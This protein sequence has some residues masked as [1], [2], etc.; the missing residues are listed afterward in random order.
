MGKAAR[1]EE[2]QEAARDGRRMRT[3]LIRRL[4]RHD[5]AG[6]A[7][8]DVEVGVQDKETRRKR[9]DARRPFLV[10]VL[11]SGH[12]QQAVRAQEV[13]ATNGER[14]HRPGERR[15]AGEADH[16][17][18]GHEDASAVGRLEVEP[19]RNGGPHAVSV[20]KAFRDGALHRLRLAA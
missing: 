1:G 5:G 3:R 18:A 11:E 2:E 16:R 15:T 14:G 6:A 8:V 20:F 17:L 19:P 4:A 7:A 10:L 13:R 9:E 12:E